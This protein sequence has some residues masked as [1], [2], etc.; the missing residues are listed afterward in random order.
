MTLAFVVAFDVV[1]KLTVAL[2]L[3]LTELVGIGCINSCALYV[4]FRLFRAGVQSSAITLGMLST[5]V[6]GVNGNFWSKKSL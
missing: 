2:A 3:A 5:A 1:L 6:S 4:V